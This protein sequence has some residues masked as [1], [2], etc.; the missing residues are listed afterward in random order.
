MVTITGISSFLGK[1]AISK[2]MSTFKKAAEDL[3]TG[4]NHCKAD[5]A[6]HEQNIKETQTS[7]NDLNK[8]IEQANKFAAKLNAFLED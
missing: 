4:I 7:I 5:V 2:A 8:T 6:K 1:N 3:Q